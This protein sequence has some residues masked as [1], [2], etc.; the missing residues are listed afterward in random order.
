MGV[1]QVLTLS[2][3]LVC[4][5][6]SQLLKCTRWGGMLVHKDTVRIY[7]LDPFLYAQDR[8]CGYIQRNYEEEY[9]TNPHGYR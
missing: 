2:V 8:A 1:E 7:G 6:F 4:L 3:V 9:Y 5:C